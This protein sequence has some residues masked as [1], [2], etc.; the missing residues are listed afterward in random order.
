MSTTD[1]GSGPITP[2]HI[3]LMAPQFRSGAYWT[4]YGP[5][6]QKFD[7]AEAAEAEAIHSKLS[8]RYD[9]VPYDFAKQGLPNFWEK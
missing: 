9:V 8:G 7:S 6:I 2:Y 1:A 3:F 5:S 4:P